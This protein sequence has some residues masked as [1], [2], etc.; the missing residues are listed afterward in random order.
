MFPAEA[1][2][3]HHTFMEDDL[4]FDQPGDPIHSQSIYLTPGMLDM[5][6][7]KYNVR[8]FMMMRA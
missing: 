4:R 5:L 6:A 2:P 8:P 3:S 1:S 7:M